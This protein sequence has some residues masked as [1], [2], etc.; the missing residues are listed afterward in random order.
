MCDNRHACHNIY[1][2]ADTRSAGLTTCSKQKVALVY[3]CASLIPPH[4]SL[5]PYILRSFLSHFLPF[6]H[7]SLISLFS[8]T[9]IS[10]FVPFFSLCPCLIRF[11]LPIFFFFLSPS[12]SNFPLLYAHFNSFIYFD[13]K[14]LYEEKEKDMCW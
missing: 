8:F 13:T 11:F 3:V 4:F 12:S 2:S 14:F 5:F 10:T 6:C 7:S 9:F 1:Y